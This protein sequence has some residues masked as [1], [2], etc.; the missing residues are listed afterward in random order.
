MRDLVRCSLELS[1][2]LND[3]C[4]SCSALAIHKGIQNAY[5]RIFYALLTVHL[6]ICL[7]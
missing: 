6:D 3:Q 4:G 5:K 7:Q 1:L 2:F